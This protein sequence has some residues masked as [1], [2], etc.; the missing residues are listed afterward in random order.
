ML[1]GDDKY[2]VAVA[3]PILS[4]GDVLGGVLFLTEG[5]GTVGEVELKLV[6][7]VSM[8]LGKQMEN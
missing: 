3:A 4:E 8:F 5:T 1:A 2:R 7:T 6:Q